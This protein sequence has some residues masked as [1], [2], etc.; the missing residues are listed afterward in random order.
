MTPHLTITPSILYFGTPVALLSTINPDGSAN[1][2][3][4]SSAWAL[5]QS[6]LLGLG[7]TGQTASNLG[8]RSELVI[9][10]PGPELWHAVEQLGSL[11]GRNPVPESRASY[12]YEPD[13]FGAA[14]LTSLA[15][16][17]VAPP[18]VAECL[19]QL[20]AR[21]VDIRQM[22]GEH[23]VVEA[24]VVR[25]H[26]APDIVLPGT[27]HIDPGVWQPLIY[28]FRHYFGLSPQ[29]LGESGITLT[30]KQVCRSSAS[31]ADI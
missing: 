20:E 26:A 27:S 6:V 5:G 4:I 25:V 11:T 18:R 17:L 13:K 12:T 23:L 8:E 15:S 30:P 16:E 21:A 2:A 19:L 7:T 10:L 1:L 24:E 3:P 9:N 29:Q 22:K 14:G 31:W 28:S